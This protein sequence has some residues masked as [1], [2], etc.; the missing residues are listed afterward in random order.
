ME[1]LDILHQDLAEVRKSLPAPAPASHAVQSVESSPMVKQADGEASWQAYNTFAALLKYTTTMDANRQIVLR[2]VSDMGQYDWR[3]RLTPIEVRSLADEADL[4]RLAIEDVKATIKAEDWEVE[5]DKGVTLNKDAEAFLNRPDGETYWD[6]WASMLLEEAMVTDAA[7]IFP[8]WRA[9]RLVRLEVIDGTTIRPKPDKTGRLPDPPVKAYEQTANDRINAWTKDELWMLISNKRIG[10]LRGFSPVEQVAARASVNV[11]K[12][13]K[14]LTRWLK[15]GV[16]A[17]FLGSPDG[18]A[19]EGDNGIKAYQRW[20]D[21][22]VRR[23][24][25]ESTMQVVAG[26]P[27]VT[28]IPPLRIDKEHE[29]ILVRIICKAIGSDPTSMISQV[30]YSTAD[31]LS[32]WAALRGVYPYL[33]FL[34][35]IADK[36]LPLA[37]FEGHRLRWKSHRN[38]SE[39]AQRQAE[40]AEYESGLRAWEE[41][42]EALGQETKPE[43]LKGKHFVVVGKAIQEF[44]PLSDPQ[45]PKPSPFFPP[46]NAPPDQQG[47]QPEQGPPGQRPGGGNEPASGPPPPKGTDEAGAAAAKACQHCGGLHKEGGGRDFYAATFRADAERAELRRWETVVRKAV[48]QGREP[49]EFEC[50]AL[51]PWKQSVIRKALGHPALGVSVFGKGGL[52]NAVRVMGA[53]IGFTASAR[54]TQA[55][56]AGGAAWWAVLK[57]YA[58]AIM[59][60]AMAEARKSG[61]LAKATSFEAALQEAFDDVP[62]PSVDTWNDLVRWIEQCYQ[63][64]VDDTAKL[65]GHGVQADAA[66]AYAQQRAGSLIGRWWSNATQSWVDNPNEAWSITESMRGQAASVVQAAIGEQ[67]TEAQLQDA[68]TGM[69]SIERAATISRTETGFAYN[70]GAASNYAAN[71]VE[72]VK[73]TD[74]GFPSSCDACNEASGQVWTVDEFLAKPLEH[75]N[76]SRVGLPA[77]ESEYQE[78][79][80]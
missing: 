8:W 25:G 43:K 41:M 15:G 72:Y 36:A 73:I 9:G 48:R 57:P 64:G 39:Y 14:D 38:A 58:D 67:W 3:M 78:A 24:E 6:T 35:S 21:D 42:R 5:V 62:P 59:Q 7:C 27:K 74:G 40:Q 53:E 69:F 71:G 63:I 16:P 47:V 54:A 52:L 2:A 51:P 11:S 17:G 70:I 60:T 34:K 23:L 76:C 10:T 20:I 13:A 61:K 45:A 28:P 30:N 49:K 68:L 19:L 50:H 29:E 80:A 46:P 44:D 75:P 18:M 4:L 37:G 26:N 56:E 12:V 1:P 66:Y 77:D 65:L 32:R 22:R 79:A 55:T 31:A 33:W